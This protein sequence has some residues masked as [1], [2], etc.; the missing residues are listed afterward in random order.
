MFEP[1]SRAEGKAVSHTS[2]TTVPCTSR[3]LTVNSFLISYVFEGIFCRGEGD[4]NYNK[5]II[6][7]TI[8][9]IIIIIME[10][11]KFLFAEN[12]YIEIED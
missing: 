5:L 7:I 9:I 10:T 3:F 1:I 4:I 6:I 11:C 12:K 8:I 2:F